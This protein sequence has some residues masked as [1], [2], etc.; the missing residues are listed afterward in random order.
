VSLVDYPLRAVPVQQVDGQEQG[1]RHKLEGSVGLDQEVKKV[2]AHE[3]LNLGLN[4]DGLD[5]GDGL[6]L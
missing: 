1:R 2:R 4:I 5:V 3:P 6:T